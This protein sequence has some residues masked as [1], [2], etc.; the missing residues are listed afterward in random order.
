MEKKFV[1][2]E[3]LTVEEL[4]EELNNYEGKSVTVNVLNGF[5]TALCF[6][7]FTS[8]MDN[9]SNNEDIL[10]LMDDNGIN[11]DMKIDDV[12]EI[13]KNNLFNQLYIGLKNK[14]IIQIF[15]EIEDYALCN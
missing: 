7:G 9:N 15:A 8:Y 1:E 2:E 14:Q 5:G 11:C 13:K 4:Q 3:N 10:M 12:T 6:D